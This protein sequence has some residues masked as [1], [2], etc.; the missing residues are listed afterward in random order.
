VV[1]LAQGRP[2]QIDHGFWCNRLRDAV[3][4]R[5]SFAA[6][7][8]RARD[9]TGYRVVHGENDGLPGL[10]ID[11]YD[12]TLVI[13]LYSAAWFAHLADLVAAIAEVLVPENVVLRLARSVTVPPGAPDDAT[14]LVGP[15]PEPV[16]FL[17]H[18]LTFES[19]PL[20]GQKTGHFLDQR[21][22]RHRVGLAADG[23]RVLDV[24]SHAGGFSVH[25]AAG[26]AIEV[27][28]VDQAATALDAA[29][30]NMSLNRSDA[31]VSRCRFSTRRGDAFEALDSL[32]DA[33]RQ[34]DIVVIDPPSFAPN[35]RSIGAALNSYARLTA[36][37]LS[38]LAP[39]G[40]LVQAS[41]SSRISADAFLDCVLAS[42]EGVGRPL[43]HIEVTGH[44]EDHP[45]DFTEGAYLK[46]IFAKA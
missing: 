9:T 30:T 19:F 41:C 6:G 26:G 15:G 12:T 3:A 37:G 13:K 40:L 17:E 31:A 18:G 22:N 35:E 42:A 20:T 24:F 10:I 36:G 45:I 21:D 29:S 34:Y 46:A 16:A 43:D 28:A 25:A 14:V 44:A 2:T 27:M 1:D 32:A 38:V 7:G 33:G 23:A 11:R 5:P 4:R 39:G 8:E